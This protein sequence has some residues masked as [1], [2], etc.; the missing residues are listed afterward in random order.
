M[1][2]RTPHETGRVQLS[3]S[4]YGPIEVVLCTFNGEKYIREQVESILQQRLKPGR[5]SIYD[6]CS[7]DRTRDIM[8]EMMR[9]ND[10][11]VEMVM[12]VNSETL[13]YVR[14]FEQGIRN[15]TF[16]YVALS[17]Q[18]DIWNSDKLEVLLSA[19]DEE[20]GIVFSN[21]L[22]VDEHAV[23]IHH[24]LWE[25][26]R[27]TK[28]RQAA[29]RS[30]DEVQQLLLQQN[31]VTGAALMMRTELATLLPSFPIATSHDYWMAII[32]AELSRLKPVERT[33]YKYRQHAMNIIGQRPHTLP[34]RIVNALQNAETRYQRELETYAQIALA[35]E[36]HENLYE[37]SVRFEEKAAFLRDR[38]EAINAGFRG[39]MSLAQMLLAGKYRRF[40]RAATAMFV[41]DVCLQW[42]R[43]LRRT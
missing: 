7:R 33:L 18:D 28:K 13:G 6:D 27:L 11:G 17:D 10:S 19:F 4:K 5:L 26:I 2:Q 21:A 1:T 34:R 24:T 41:K 31:F 39:S 40:C 22:L 38:M 16:K 42:S 43:W 14:N 23:S 25:V 29:F 32:V 12:H 20:T 3:G 37:A 9:T 8:E 15:A 35:L 30:R 36:E